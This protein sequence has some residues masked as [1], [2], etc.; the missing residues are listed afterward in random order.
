MT[1]ARREASFG[2]ALVLAL[3]A[4]V[5]AMTP[6]MCTRAAGD[7]ASRCLAA[8]AKAKPAGRDVKPLLD[9][10]GPAVEKGCTDDSARAIGYFGLADVA[11]R[12]R[13]AC[14]DFGDVLVGFAVPAGGLSSGG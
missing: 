4:P 3:A 14:A 12:M 5:I 6:A 7:A 2:I 1:A 11:L 8:Y 13:D 10:V 9:A